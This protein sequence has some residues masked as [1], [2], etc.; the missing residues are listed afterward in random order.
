MTGADNKITLSAAAA[1]YIASLS[2]SKEEA[3]QIEVYH[4]VRWFNNEKI[5]LSLTADEVVTY[6]DHLSSS[7]ADSE[8]KVESIKLFL[9]YLKK[10]GWH[11]EN[12][13]VCLKPRK[14]RVKMQSVKARVV[15]SIM[16]TRQGYEDMRVEI[17]KLKE[18]RLGVIEDIRRAAADKDLSENAPYHAAREE[19]ARLDGRIIELEETLK[20]VTFVEDKP[21]NSV[22][23]N[24]GDTVTLKDLDSNEECSY[25]LV[26]PREINP[27]QGKIS[28]SSPIGRAIIGRGEGD[29]IK[30]AVPAGKLRY[31]IMKLGNNI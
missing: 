10:E 21:N 13:S 30:I 15:K 6:A 25:T 24:L 11:K 5:A 18:K 31:C 23:A 8:K 2:H 29:I 12:L 26:N 27:A 4:F 22:K 17:E 1:R 3:S 19:K 14:T 20:T 16:L 9:H 28:A 7:S